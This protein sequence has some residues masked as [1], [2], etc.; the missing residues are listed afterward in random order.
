MDD[1][2]W[3]RP[4]DDA[5][6]ATKLKNGTPNTKMAQAKYKNGASDLFTRGLG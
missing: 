5:K 3:A 6:L 4:A 2:D 1:D